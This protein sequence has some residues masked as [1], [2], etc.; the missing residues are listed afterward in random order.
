MHNIVSNTV[1]LGNRFIECNC[2]HRTSGMVSDTI[3][4]QNMAYH[5]RE[6]EAELDR[7]AQIETAYL[8]NQQL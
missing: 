1:S 6:A 4:E 3:A 8:R 2:G 7:Q 5:I